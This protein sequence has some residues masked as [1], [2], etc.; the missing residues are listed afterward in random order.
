MATLKQNIKK[1]RTW[2]REHDDKP[3]KTGQTHKEQHYRQ[4]KRHDEDIHGVVQGYD[5]VAVVDNKAPESSSM[6][7]RLVH[8]RSMRCLRPM[9]EGTAR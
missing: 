7:K 6:Q 8:P 4:R 1:I 2:L 9:V 3:G 5:G